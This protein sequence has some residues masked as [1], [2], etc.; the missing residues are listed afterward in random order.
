MNGTGNGPDH[1]GLR[2]NLRPLRSISSAA[3]P[4]QPDLPTFSTRHLRHRLSPFAVKLSPKRLAAVIVPVILGGFFWVTVPAMASSLTDTPSSPPVVVVTPGAGT[5]GTVTTTPQG[6]APAN[7]PAQAPAPQAPAQAPQAPAQAP[8]APAQ[9]AP[10][11][12]APAA[13]PAQAAPA[14]AAPA[15]RAVG[16]VR[17]L[18]APITGAADG[19]IRIV[20]VGICLAFSGFA[21]LTAPK[22]NPHAV[23]G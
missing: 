7:Q 10:A 18:H 21:L 12:A 3:A 20:L 8:A 13:A 23:V 16:A 15:P 11:Q 22:R 19:V 14:Q 4:I 1:T 2:L 6:Q 17:G 5:T 9:A